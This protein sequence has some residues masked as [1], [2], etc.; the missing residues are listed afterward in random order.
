MAKFIDADALIQELCGSCADN[1]KCPNLTGSCYEFDVIVDQPA[2]DV[3]PTSVYRQVTWER[4]T[5]I[6]QLHSIGKEFGEKM[7]DVAPVVHGE[8]LFDRSAGIKS[9]FK[10]NV[11]GRY[12][13]AFADEQKGKRDVCEA[14]PYCHCGAKMDS[15]D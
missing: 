11:C 12:V 6:K 4:D 15:E 13:A 9:Y 3:V 5:A 7:D 1:G 8:W 2:A 10:C 14:F